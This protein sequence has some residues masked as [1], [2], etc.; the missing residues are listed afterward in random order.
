MRN[1][2]AFLVLYYRKETKTDENTIEQKSRQGKAFAE[3]AVFTTSPS[4][5]KMAEE[6]FHAKM[7]TSPGTVTLKKLTLEILLLLTYIV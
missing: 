1:S 3:G 4:F 6:P 2:L 5:I 7:D